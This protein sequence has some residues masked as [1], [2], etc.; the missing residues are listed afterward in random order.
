ME[1]QEQLNYIDSC[2]NQI[3]ILENIF[4]EFRQF[5]D[6]ITPITPPTKERRPYRVSY[7]LIDPINYYRYI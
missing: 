4:H 5:D 6:A 3:P 7:D 1:L 2:T